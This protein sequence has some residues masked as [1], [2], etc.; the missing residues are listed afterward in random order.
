MTAAELY[1]TQDN[2]R[3]VVDFLSNNLAQ[4]PLKVYKRNSENDRVRDRDSDASRVLWRPND[5]QTQ[6]E[7]IRAL[8]TE[9]YIFG[10]VYVW[11]VPNADKQG[12]YD[13]HIIPTDWVKTTKKTAYGPVLIT[14]KPKA[15]NEA[16]EIPSNEWVRFSTYNPGDPSTSIS[17]ISALKQTLYEQVES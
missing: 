7:F 3:A 10:C 9:Y 5:Y 4:L 16:V 14:V 11:V 1:R 17:A 2:L 13:L 8:C 6:F 12:G 15:W